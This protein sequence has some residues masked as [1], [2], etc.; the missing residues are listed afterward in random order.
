MFVFVLRLFWVYNIVQT[1][2]SFAGWFLFTIIV[3]SLSSVRERLEAGITR[4]RGIICRVTT[5]LPFSRSQQGFSRDI[6]RRF[7]GGDMGLRARE[8]MA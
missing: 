4:R 8:V 6:L 7:V 2:Y 1:R 3:L 5:V